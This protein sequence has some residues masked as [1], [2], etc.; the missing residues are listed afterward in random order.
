[1]A[2]HLDIQQLHQLV[3]TLAQQVQQHET[4][5]S[6]LIALKEKVSILEQEKFFLE[7]ENSKL[8]SRVR[9]LESNFSMSEGG[10]QVS[11]V[12]L[13]TPT[14]T[15]PGS[16]DSSIHASSWAAK[17]AKPASLPARP[18]RVS[19][20]KRVAAARAFVSPAA[21]G[22]QGFTYVY[23]GRSRKINRSE[24]RSRLRRS[25]VDTG[26]ILDISFPASGVLGLLM[27]V[28]YVEQ[29]TA[30]MQKVG[31]ELIGGFDP[32]D[33]KHLADPKF[34][35]LSVDDRAQQMHSLVHDRALDTLS[36][37]RPV[38]VGPLARSFM[39]LGWI[40]H[41]DLKTVLSV[42]R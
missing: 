12:S 28:Q 20:K 9:T 5:F 18:A 1:M 40:D 14:A 30:T 32:L 4:L 37:V 35:A 2:T 21:K 7:S 13:P 3:L 36:F 19:Q 26:R 27:H 31:A 33:P 24:V 42:V 6:D 22:P 16:G 29:F 25:G 15:H 23:L 11:S 41:D 38:V 39:E 17:A 34:A 10:I 8:L